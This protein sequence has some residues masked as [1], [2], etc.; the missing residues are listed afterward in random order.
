MS[1]QY[2]AISL[3]NKIGFKHF[4]NTINLLHT[5]TFLSFLTKNI[6][7]FDLEDQSVNIVWGNKGCF[8]NNRTETYEGMRGR[9]EDS[10][11]SKP[12]GTCTN[13][14]VLKA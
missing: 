4:G 3:H 12:G 1:S 6:L 8:Y 14:Y 11:M 7:C 9:N 10:S 5:K 13:H 2:C